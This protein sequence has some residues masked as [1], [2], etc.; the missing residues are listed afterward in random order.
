MHASCLVWG[1]LCL[2]NRGILLVSG[3]PE[4]GMESRLLI[5]GR[6][7]LHNNLL[8]YLV[9]WFFVTAV[10]Q[11]T[12]GTMAL[13]HNQRVTAEYVMPAVLPACTAQII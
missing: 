4:G 12:A 2:A 8:L 13:Y 3:T 7:R 6:Q 1:K 11:Q 5:N 10:E 9:C